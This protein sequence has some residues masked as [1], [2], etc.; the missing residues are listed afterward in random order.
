MTAGI[1]VGDAAAARFL[2]QVGP[3]PLMTTGLAVAVGGFVGFTRIGVHTSYLVHVLPPELLIGFGLGLVLTAAAD[4][5]LIGV[6]PRDAGVASALLNTSEQVS[7]S[8]GIALLSTFA[9]SA[10]ARYLA[11]HPRSSAT[12]AAAR[13]EPA[14]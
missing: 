10:T 11:T 12:A 14:M 3:R 4:T 9:A 7:S 6:D 8:L 13:G 5:A 1:V 2:P